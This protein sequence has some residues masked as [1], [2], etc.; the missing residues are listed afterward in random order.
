VTIGDHTH[1]YEMAPPQRG[2]AERVG[3]LYIVRIATTVRSECAQSVKSFA[4]G[5]DCDPLGGC[6]WAE[7]G[8]GASAEGRTNAD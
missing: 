6:P 7:C 4:G 3:Y 2:R 1:G 8:G 5:S